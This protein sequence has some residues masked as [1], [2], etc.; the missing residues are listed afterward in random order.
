ME[1]K[2][3]DERKD[4]YLSIFSVHTRKNVKKGYKACFF[5]RIFLFKTWYK[6]QINQSIFGLGKNLEKM[7]DD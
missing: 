7:H 2:P 3:V 4:D 1:M 6:M 5:P